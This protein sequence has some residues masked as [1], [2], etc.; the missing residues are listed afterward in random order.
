M[1]RLALAALVLGTLACRRDPI[2]SDLD[3]LEASLALAPAQRPA[4]EAFRKEAE[5]ADS[6]RAAWKVQLKEAAAGERFDARRAQVAA[7]LARKD[8]G[9]LIEAWAR[10][11]AALSPAQR[12]AVRA[13]LSPE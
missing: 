10:L 7:D 12:T 9:R 1:R 5:A 13:Q 4:W 8:A 6:P 2:G 11:D 3:R